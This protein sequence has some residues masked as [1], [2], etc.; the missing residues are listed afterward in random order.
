MAGSADGRPRQPLGGMQRNSGIVVARN[1]FRADG[2]PWT[3]NRDRRRRRTAAVRARGR[4]LR[5]RP[6]VQLSDLVGKA[7]ALVTGG[8][9]PESGSIIGSQALPDS[10]NLSAAC[11][12]WSTARALRMRRRD[13][14]TGTLR[15]L[16]ARDAATAAT[17]RCAMAVP[18]VSRGTGGP[19]SPGAGGGDAGTPSREECGHEAAPI[20][21]RSSKDTIRVRRRPSVHGLRVTSREFAWLAGVNRT[22]GQKQVVVHR[23]SLRAG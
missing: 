8:E 21:T 23:G 17:P 10:L 14:R 19:G 15:D 12:C 22:G 1:F 3:R 18:F 13:R 9:E 20:A 6:P 11:A 5:S 2:L 16:G 4:A 7:S